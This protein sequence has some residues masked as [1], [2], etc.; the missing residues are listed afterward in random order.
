MKPFF[1]VLIIPTHSTFILSV[2]PLFPPPLLLATPPLSPY[3]PSAPTDVSP[4]KCEGLVMTERQ[5]EAED[6]ELILRTAQR[7]K[8]EGGKLDEHT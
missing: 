8:D 6:S 3:L 7:M 2:S 1:F 5:K 4:C